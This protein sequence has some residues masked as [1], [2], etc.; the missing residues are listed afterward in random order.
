MAKTP[1]VTFKKDKRPT[2]LA[3]VG[4]KPTWDLKLNKRRFGCIWSPD[5]R[6]EDRNG[7]SL[8]IMAMKTETV[9]DS[10]PNCPWKWIHFKARWKT[11]QEAKDW[12]Q[13]NIVEIQTKYTLRYD[14]ED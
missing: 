6:M 8:G 12:I 9:T 3:S 4:W 10:N 11:E 13:A 2:G 5:H 14:D 7:Y 1:K